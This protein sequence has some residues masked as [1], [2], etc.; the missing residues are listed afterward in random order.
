MVV[1]NSLRQ[2]GRTPMKTLAFLVLLILAVTFFMLGFQL[3]TGARDNIDRID[4]AYM[5]I[6]TV[7]QKAT[8]VETARMWDAETKSYTYF[9]SPGYDGIVPESVLD[10]E[11][12]DYILK[13]EKRPIYG[14]YM[15]GFVL[16]TDPDWEYRYEDLYLIAELQPYEDCVTD[17]PVRMK[18]KRMLRGTLKDYVDEIWF[19][20]HW[21]DTP[22]KLFADKT[23]IVSLFQDY[24][25]DFDEGYLL[26]MP[27]TGIS[28]NQRDINGKKITDPVTKQ[29]SWEDLWDEVT[30]GF[31]DT[32]RGKAW[33]NLVESVEWRKYTIPVMPT[34]D[35]KLLMPFYD[36]DAW[37]VEGR[38]ISREEYENGDKVCLV[39]RNFAANNNLTAGGSLQLPLYFADYWAP[40]WYITSEEILNAKGEIYPVFEDSTYTI[41][42]IYEALTASFTETSDYDLAENTV[43]IPSASV[44]NSDENNIAG[45]GQMEG[46]TTSFQ[47]PNGRIGEF[48]AAWEKQGIPTLE[49]NFYD[50]GYTK[51]K[52]GLDDMMNTAGV[53]LISG[54]VIT[55]LIL[56][57]FCHLFIAKQRKRTAIERSL[58]MS[59]KR[60][61][62]SLLTGIL[63]IVIPACVIGSAVSFW[64]T[65]YAAER[66]TAAHNEQAFDTMYSDW[67]NADTGTEEFSVSM[68]NSLEKSWV[69]L[70]VIPVA[71]VIALVNIRSNLKSEPL[72]LLGEKER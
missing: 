36:G 57:L 13:P 47:I 44:K 25:P 11:G 6:G 66:M 26:Y 37:M 56:I 53:L 12:A 15:P 49:I 61:I 72:R 69:G 39:E 5:T 28:T 22:I 42:G 68:D 60:C 35:T 67:V 16:S 1:I 8:T 48:T 51:I 31:Y 52:A 41:V 3:W 40:P 14:A 63:V 2:L 70:G 45:M 43:I 62:A 46:Y 65:G 21:N 9:N 55:L 19:C 30:E 4:K 50:K 24:H 29:E 17:K 33:L 38:D 27:G 64:L 18:L 34:Q 59:K 7:V 54:G 20:D 23:Y 32:P 58:G 71:L 10:F